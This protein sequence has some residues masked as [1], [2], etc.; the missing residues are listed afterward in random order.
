MFVHVV[1]ELDL[2]EGTS[3]FIQVF[4][5]TKAHSMYKP[6][7]LWCLLYR[8]IQAVASASYVATVV[9][10]GRKLFIKLDP[11]SRPY[12]PEMNFPDKQNL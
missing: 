11:E 12:S 4:D 1:N 6:R 7:S 9:S 8:S 2:F 5:F 10:Y 3:F